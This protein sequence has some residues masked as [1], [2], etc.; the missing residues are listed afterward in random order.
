MFKKK[1]SMF[2]LTVAF[3]LSI[4][5]VKSPSSGEAP[6]ISE[7]EVVSVFAEE[8]ETILTERNHLLS[9]LEV[10]LSSA[11][12]TASQVE[13]AIETIALVEELTSKEYFVE[14]Q[15]KESGYED[16]L[17]HVGDGDVNVKVYSSEFS[18]EEAVSV[19]NNIKEVF[20]ETFNV[21]I[22]IKQK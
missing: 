12:S 20:G 17:V 4:Y 9:E 11:E 14:E 16:V 7:P 22:K 1:L 18:T 5:L 8:K 10:L 21:T 2:L 19:T 6:V 15:L 3:M 13:Q